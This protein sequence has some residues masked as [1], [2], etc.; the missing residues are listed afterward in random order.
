MEIPLRFAGLTPVNPDSRAESGLKTW[1]R[2][3]G[4]A[5]DVGFYA[6]WMR[7][8]ASERIGH[9]YPKARLPTEQGGGEASVI[10]WIWART[11]RSPDP[12]WAGHVP[13]VRSWVLRKPKKNK[14][15]IWVEPLIDRVSQTVRYR[16]RDGGKPPEG[17]VRRGVGTC[18]ATGTPMPLEY[19]RKEATSGRMDAQMIAVVAEGSSGRV[20]LDVTGDDVEAAVVDVPAGVPSQRLDLYPRSISIHLY[21][22]DEWWKLFTPRQL[23]ALTTFS[24]LLAEARPVVEEHARA[25]GLVDDGVSLRGRGC[26]C[27]G[28]C[29]CRNHLSRSCS[30]P[31]R[32]PD[33]NRLHM[34]QR[35]QQ[36]PQYLWSSGH[37]HDLGFC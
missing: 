26:G 15:V 20:Y 30:E 18:V 25:A 9:V 4:L 10:A 29:G 2:A 1:V 21:G 31:N 23:A 28:V 5:Q 13:L 6:E 32:R 35:L 24:G 12:S 37:P 19:V 33:V 7:D 8:R 27:G 11:V 36:D 17:T 34:G 16:I 3:Q 14:S 22:L